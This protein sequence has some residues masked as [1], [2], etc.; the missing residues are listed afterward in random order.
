MYYIS[1]LVLTLELG[2]NQAVYCIAELAVLLI[3][4]IISLESR[5]YRD[6]YSILLYMYI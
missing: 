5:E 2:K 1:I 4:F 6:M 3:L